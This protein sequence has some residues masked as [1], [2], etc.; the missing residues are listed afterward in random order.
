M[1]QFKIT[2]S[3]TN[4]DGSTVEKYFTE[5]SKEPL[6]TQKEEIDLAKRVKQG[7]DEALAR[8]VRA[9]LRFVVSV[10]KQYQYGKL[11]LNDL[12]NEGNIGLIKAAKMFDETKGFKFISYAVWWIRQS[13]MHALDTYSRIVRIPT[14]KVQELAKL[15]NAA[16]S[17]EQ[18]MER[19]ATSDELAELLNVNVDDVKSYQTAHIRQSSLDAPFNE[20]ESN[21]LYDVMKD[22]G[23]IATD[24]N[25]AFHDSLKYELTRLL[26]FLNDRE[27]DILKRF[28]GIGQDFNQTLDD[29][30]SELSLTK[31]RVRQIKEQALKKLRVKANPQVLSAFA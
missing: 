8:L 7:D 18:K 12:I 15:S 6:L 3:I 22:P 26:S 27:A 10:A 20:E 1:K 2:N 17:I 13:I 28:F 9:N 23:D 30:A 14:N 11:P 21:C 4:R 24:H 19:E 31:E 29:I 16:A 5:V 25:V